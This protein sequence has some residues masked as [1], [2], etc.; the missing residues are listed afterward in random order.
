M[1]ESNVPDVDLT[2]YD[3]VF[4]AVADLKGNWEIEHYYHPPPEEEKDEEKREN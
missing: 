3:S 1:C 4:D 2:K